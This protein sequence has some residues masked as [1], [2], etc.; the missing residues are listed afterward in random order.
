MKVLVTDELSQEGLDMLT[1]G[2]DIQVDVRPKLAH[3]E[4][5]KIIGE[6][7]ALIVRSG[8]KVTAEVIE[9]GKRLRVIGRAGVGVD[10]VDVEAATRR[11]VLVM[12]TPAANIISAAEHTMA[13]M[14]TLAR[15]IPRADASVKAGKWERSKFTGVELMGKTLGIVGIGRVGGEVAKRA[16]AFQMKLVGYDPYISQ[17]LAVKLGVRILPLEKVLEEADFITIHTPLTPTTHH[18]IGREQLALMKP[19]AFVVNCARGG[20]IDEDALYEALKD[21]RIA[22][23]ALDVFEDEPP[24]GSKLLTLDNLVATPHLGASTKE[25][26]EKVSI[27]MAEHVKMF[28]LENKITNAV[29]VPIGRVDP[30]VAPFIGLAER[31]GAFCVQLSD[32]PVKKIEVECHGEIANM[33]TRMVTVSAIVGV[34]SIVVGESTNIINAMSIAR[35][36]GIQIMES[37]VDESSHYTNMLVLRISSDGHKAE[38]RG[39]VFPSDQYRII[40]IDEFDLDMPLEGDFLLTKHHDMPGMIG[41]IGTLLGKRDINI[42]RMGVGRTDKGGDALMLISVDQEVGKAVVAELRALPNFH[43]ARS[44]VLSHMRPRGYMNL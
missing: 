31:L 26:Q 44:I 27:E 15:N 37:K 8:T 4:L 39:T 6:Y 41:R 32:A 1:K 18:L 34:L 2:S 14:L 28:L 38:V 36:K 35:E 40:G 16:K 24:K 30:K 13:M 25:A 19:S 5:L 21:R 3:E 10:N 29:N 12:N 11:G 42:A 9:A 20:I 33:D 23:A 17:E 7:D 22:G 43:D